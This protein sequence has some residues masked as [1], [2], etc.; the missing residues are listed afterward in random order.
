MARSHSLVS[1]DLFGIWHHFIGAA[2]DFLITSFVWAFSVT[3]GRGLGVFSG[4]SPPR[5]SYRIKGPLFAREQGQP[6]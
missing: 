6:P 4:E 2:K 3:K 1:V 5:A